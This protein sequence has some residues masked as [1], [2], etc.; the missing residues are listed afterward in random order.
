MPAEQFIRE[1]LDPILEKIA[2]RGVH[3][4]TRG[5]R[6]LLQKGRAKLAA[7]DVPVVAT[8]R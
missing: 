5:E 7:R 3:S 6:K 2:Q 4:L 8:R 1:E